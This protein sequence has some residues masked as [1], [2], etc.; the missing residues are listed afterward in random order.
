MKKKLYIVMLLFLIN[1]GVVNAQ[2]EYSKDTRMIID[3]DNSVRM[4]IDYSANYELL[5]KYGLEKNDLFDADTFKINLSEKGY[6]VSESYIL[7]G[8]ALEISKSFGDLN[9]LSQLKKTQIDLTDISKE[10][11]NDSVFFQKKVGIFYTTYKA[12]FIFDYSDVNNEEVEIDKIASINFILHSTKKL[13]NHNASEILQ[14]ENITR[15][16]L[17]LGQ[18]NEVNFEIKE[19]NVIVGI[20]LAIICFI[21]MVSIILALVRKLSHKKIEYQET[22]GR[23]KRKQK[24]KKEKKVKNKKIHNNGMTFDDEVKDNVGNPNMNNVQTTKESHN[25]GMM[26]NMQVNPINNQNSNMQSNHIQNA[27]VNHNQNMHSN[28][29]Q[30]QSGMM[31]NQ[32]IKPNNNIYNQPQQY[33]NNNQTYQNNMQKPDLMAPQQSINNPD[34]F[35]QQPV[36][37]PSNN[38]YNSEPTDYTS[39]FNQSFDYKDNNKNGM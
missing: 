21:V 37:A 14:N 23:E 27:H 26:P 24:V 22:K 13:I 19:F 12:N 8:V 38:L 6:D 29:M 1:I 31:Q 39:V 32:N 2:E 9:A 10:T 11:Y 30:H 36:N 3:N 20:I 4:I 7:N 33:S 28:Q 17:K 34:L 35:R 18:K 25:H 15:W 16:D 5:D